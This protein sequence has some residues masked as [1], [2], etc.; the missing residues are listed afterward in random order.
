MTGYRRGALATASVSNSRFNV[1]ASNGGRRSSAL[2]PRS[3]TNK[4]IQTNTVYQIDCPQNTTQGDA[5]AI[6]D[7]LKSVRFNGVSFAGGNLTGYTKDKVLVNFDK[8]VRLKSV[9]GVM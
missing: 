4:A 7:T 8:Q 3:W 2:Y 5:A 6:N 1:K 9:R